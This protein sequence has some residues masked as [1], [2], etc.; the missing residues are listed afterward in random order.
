MSD[1]T[2][3]TFFACAPL[4]LVVMGVS[5]VGKTTIAKGLADELGWAFEEGDLLHPKANV[6]KM[7]A[8][9]PL[10]DEDRAPWLARIAEWVDTRIAAGESGIITCS[11]LKRRYRDTI[12]H[13]GRSALFVFLDGPHD[14]VGERLASRQGHF[15]PPSLLDS[16]F[17]ALEPPGPDEPALRFD[18]GPPP[19][20]IVATILRKLV[21]TRRIAGSRSPCNPP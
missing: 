8:G 17:E 9:H 2:P 12:A 20:E 13:G 5:G 18:V 11:A 14:T 21:D 16:Q 19:Q 1:D 6:D 7:A 15:M 10:T 4:V 3:A